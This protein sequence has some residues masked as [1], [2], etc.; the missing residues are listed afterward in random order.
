MPVPEG[1][2][3]LR[4][5]LGI[6]IQTFAHLIIGGPIR[7]VDPA[8]RKIDLHGPCKLGI[9]VDPSTKNATNLELIRNRVLG[10]Q[11]T[12]EIVIVIPS[13]SPL[14][15][16]PQGIELAQDASGQISPLFVLLGEIPG[17]PKCI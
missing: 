8:R 6:E 10:G 11:G 14:V 5:K 12:K 3:M 2:L 7:T 9:V 17:G 16:D 1:I 4:N 15:H 13:E